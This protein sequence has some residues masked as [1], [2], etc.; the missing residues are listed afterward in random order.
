MT[1]Q[2]SLVQYLVFASFFDGVRWVRGN[3]DLESQI[4][5]MSKTLDNNWNICGGRRL[6]EA[7]KWK[8]IRK[9]EKLVKKE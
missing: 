4:Q 3:T 1:N 5:N 2:L 6:E 8:G 9:N 7:P